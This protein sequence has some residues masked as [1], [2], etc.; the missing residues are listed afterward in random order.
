MRRN[1]EVLHIGLM[2]LAWQDQGNKTCM[3][4]W[5]FAPQDWSQ[6]SEEQVAGTTGLGRCIGNYR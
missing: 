4:Y 5:I 3:I 1:H 6:N 2:A